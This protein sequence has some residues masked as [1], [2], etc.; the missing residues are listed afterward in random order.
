MSAL[1]KL[2]TACTRSRGF[3]REDRKI[4]GK[5]VIVG[6]WSHESTG[7][8]FVTGRFEGTGEHGDVRAVNFA[9]VWHFNRFGQVAER[10]TYL[11]FGHAYVER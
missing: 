4:Q 2:T 10:Q 9:D 7:T 1:E 6:L 11:A 3:F 5:H 8:V